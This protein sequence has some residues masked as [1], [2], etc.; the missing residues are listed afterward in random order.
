MRI[1]ALI[2]LI[3]CA[4]CSDQLTSPKDPGSQINL[5]TDK[6]FY[7]LLDT[8]NIILKNNSAEDLMVGLRCGNF[9]E[10]SSQKQS[11]S[12]LLN[13][14]EFWYMSLG[15]ATFPDTVKSKLERVYSLP[16]DIFNN[17]GNFR[18]VLNAYILQRD[19]SLILTS[20][21]FNIE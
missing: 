8:I 1:T 21:F 2:I 10:L 5:S 19:S 17:N 4:G 14:P 3:I 11:D 15:C 12:G 20:N 9:L 18:F 7:T 13:Y 6:S 16:A